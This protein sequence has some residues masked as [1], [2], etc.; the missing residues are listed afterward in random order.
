MRSNP[1]WPEVVWRVAQ[2]V[3][4]TAST[5]LGSIIAADAACNVTTGSTSG[6]T[7]TVNGT[8][9]VNNVGFCVTNDVVLWG[10]YGSSNGAN[11]AVDTSNDVPMTAGGLSYTNLSYSTSRATYTLVPVN[12]TDDLSQVPEYDITANTIS[13]SGSDTITLWYASQCSHSL[14][15]C[16]ASTLTDASFTVTVN[17][18]PPTVTSIAPSSGSSSGG[19]SVMITGT[20]FAGTAGAG[21]VKFGT[22]NATSYTVNSVTSITA[23][24]PPG[25]GM[26]HV[27]VTNNS[28]TSASSAADQFTYVPPPTVT[29]ISPSAGSTGGGTSVTITGTNFTGATGVTIG[30]IGAT[31]VSVANATTIT[32]MTLAHAAG[33]VNVVV[34]TPGGT[35]TGTNLYTYAAAPTFSDDPIQARMTPVRV[36]HITELRQA[37]DQLRARY[38]LAAYSWTDPILTVRVSAIKV[39]DLTDLRTALDAVYVAAHVS[40]PT[41]TTP[42]PSAGTTVIAAV[43]IEELR[44]AVLGIW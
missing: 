34:T 9:P 30:G 39:A 2:F 31:G 20:G 24:A 6:V 14:Q 22:V 5:L 43:H 25:S 38:G 10:L 1:H 35:G 13:G 32:A 16:G 3:C 12:N 37:I 28:R 33:I 23:T 29:S 26:V 36:V 21:G 27:T 15:G 18:P 7:I 4:L 19:T 40:P 42:S 41:Y 11:P 8:G 44:A 17:L